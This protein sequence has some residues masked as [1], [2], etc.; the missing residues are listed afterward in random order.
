MCYFE[1]MLHQ[2]VI[3]LM[4]YFTDLLNGESNETCKKNVYEKE[5]C[6]WDFFFFFLLHKTILIFITVM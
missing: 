3:S 5:A 2:T 4:H 1:A 6:F